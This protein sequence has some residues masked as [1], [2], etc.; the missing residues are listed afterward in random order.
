[1]VLHAT[2]TAQPVGLRYFYDDASQL[3]RVLDSTG[4][5]VEYTYD[6][7]GNIAAVTRSTVAPS[8]LAILNVVPLSGP[9]GQTVTIYG[10]NF[11][12]SASGDTVQFGGVAATV[13]SASATA[14]VVTMPAG[15]TTGQISVTVNGVTATSG[16]LTF[17]PPPSITSITPPYGAAGATVSNVVIAGAN[18]SGA[19]FS[20]TGG[21]TITPVSVG[22]TQAT[23]NITLEAT[24]GAYALVATS[25]SGVA[26]GS[27]L[28]AGNTF[29]VFGAAGTNFAENM[30]A[31]F[32]PIGQSYIYPAGTNY[33]DQQFS[34]FNAMTTSNT[35]PVIPAGSNEADVYFSAFN[36]LIPAGTPPTIPAGDNW[37]WQ[38]F[39]T[40]NKQ[41]A[42]AL[43]AMTI[44]LPQGL[45]PTTPGNGADGTAPGGQTPLTLLAGQTVE[46]S[47]R[48]QLFMQYL[49]L[50][51]GRTPLAS[52]TTGSLD[53]PFTAPFGVESLDLKA[54]G[55]TGNG[56]MAETSIETVRV[57]PDPGRT[58]AGV[59]TDAAGVPL[60][61]VL[62]SWQAQG[63]SAEYQTAGGR[64]PAR[65][66]FLSALNFA[67]PAQVFGADPMGVGLGKNYVGRLSGK[68]QI[69]T[70]GIYQFRL[71]AHARA[72]LRI[73]GQVVAD[74]SASGADATTA[75]GSVN[76]AAGA[77]EVEVTHFENGGAAALQLFWTPPG[78]QPAV[79]PPSRITA[80]APAAWQTLTGRDGRFVLHLPAA[81][82]GVAIRTAA[83]NVQVDQ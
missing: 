15:F 72:R 22:S 7:N 23:V 41:N 25:P 82:D 11:A 34:T 50:Y 54:V 66:S 47:I 39:S 81:L 28:T 68:I 67:N 42:A 24:L 46:L 30:F 13:Q 38:L 77:H 80:E 33:A 18:L 52:S 8:S 4:N 58:I 43:T 75:E 73:D 83:G 59:V 3:F 21:G 45:R 79:V 76:L 14:L 69:D 53:L 78:G 1:M 55:H 60:P 71:L 31:I 37:A 63:W 49:E 5:L 9:A 2:A 56:A 36:P 17:A 35:I 44:A 26:T 16:E 32:N 64:P 57:I 29:F 70:E 40:T 19:T 6:P 48:P 61:G 62:V 65:V 27:Q 51:T 74:V 20:L 12:T 10:Q